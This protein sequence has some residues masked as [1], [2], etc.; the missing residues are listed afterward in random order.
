MYVHCTLYIYGVFF[1]K[2][3]T[4]FIYYNYIAKNASEKS[5]ALRMVCMKTYY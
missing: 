5:L 2:I 3:D 1:R 4:V